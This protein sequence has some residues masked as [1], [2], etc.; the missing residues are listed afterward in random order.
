M[1]NTALLLTSSLAIVATLRWSRP[2][3]TTAFLNAF[4]GVEA[5]TSE[6]F[7]YDLKDCD[8]EDFDPAASKQQA[9]LGVSIDGRLATNLPPLDKSICCLK[10]GPK[11]PPSKKKL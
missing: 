11:T 10:Y 2:E 8:Y 4:A 7:H 3:L 1:K 6:G 5:K 9:V